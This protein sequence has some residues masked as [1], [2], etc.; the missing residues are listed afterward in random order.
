M[1]LALTYES[2]TGRDMLRTYNVTM[3]ITCVL[4]CIL[5]TKWDEVGVQN[6]KSR[7]PVHSLVQEMSLEIYSPEVLVWAISMNHYPIS[8]PHCESLSNWSNG[9][10][11]LT[12]LHRLR[13][14]GKG[15]SVTRAEHSAAAKHLEA[16]SSKPTRERVACPEASRKRSFADAALVA[17][18]APPAQVD[19]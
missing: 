6:T 16:D 11:P 15:R 9:W 18:T 10:L 3:F 14:P 13:E 8:P 2:Y 12:V 1:R 5:P 4:Q 7:T 17:E 19:L